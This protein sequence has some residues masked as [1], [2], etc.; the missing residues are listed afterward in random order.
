MRITD[1]HPHLSG[2]KRGSSCLI[3]INGR[4][5]EAFIGETVATVLLASGRF[6]SLEAAAKPPG[7]CGFF[8]G[9]GIC[10]GCQVMVDGRLQRACVTTIE[11]E[12]AISTEVQPE[13]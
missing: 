3:T 5:L 2:V 1:H 10:F 7:L 6:P 12:M 4:Q 9:I 11:P 8:C 13:T